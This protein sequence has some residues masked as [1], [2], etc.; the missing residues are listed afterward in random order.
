MLYKDYAQ[1]PPIKRCVQHSYFRSGGREERV[2]ERDIEEMSRLAEDTHSKKIAMINFAKE[3]PTSTEI[4][5]LAR[6]LMFRDVVG[7]GICTAIEFQSTLAAQGYSHDQV[8]ALT[9]LVVTNDRLVSYGPFLEPLL[10]SK[11]TDEYCELRNEFIRIDADGSGQL[12]CAEIR[13]MLHS[14]VLEHLLGA[15]DANEVIRYMDKDGDGIVSW[16]EFRTALSGPQERIAERFSHF[17][18]N[19]RAA[20]ISSPLLAPASNI[21]RPHQLPA[22][23]PTL[24]PPTVSWAPMHDRGARVPQRVEGRPPPPWFGATPQAP[25]QPTLVNPI[26]TAGYPH[27]YAHCAVW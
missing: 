4:D 3:M 11:R 9:A 17:Q 24:I 12:S 21:G 13:A 6:A 8:D 27:P 23:Q 1:R 7:D 19:R 25:R 20:P 16:A 15:R 14:G 18:G 5:Q 26:R 10:L 22:R 2:S